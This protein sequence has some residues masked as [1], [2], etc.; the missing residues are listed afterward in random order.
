MRHEVVDSYD[1][2]IL[3]SLQFLQKA[4]AKVNQAIIAL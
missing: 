1:E 3:R 2:I 4:D